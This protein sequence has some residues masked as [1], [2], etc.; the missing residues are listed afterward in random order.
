MSCLTS[1]GT[2][3]PQTK[4]VEYTVYSD[5]ACTEC[6]GLNEQLAELGVS[7]A[8]HW[9]GVQIDPTMPVPMRPFDRRALDRIEDEISEVRRHIDGAMMRLPRGKP[10]TLKAIVAVTS[11][12]RQQ[13]GRAVLFRDA[14]YR[15]YWHDGADIS[16]GAE[17][18]RVADAV[19]IPRFVQLDHPEAEDLVE[20]WDL[21]WATERL[22]GVPRVIRGDGKILWGLKPLAEARAFF[23]L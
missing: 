2:A 10:N 13:P 20:D 15:A 17:L 16:S 19:A 12:M 5:F 18:Q 8:V 11:V 22:G 9:R 23:G 6:Y 21:D 4:I 1:I 7:A 3:I 14:L